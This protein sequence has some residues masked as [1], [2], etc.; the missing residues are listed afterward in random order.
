ML[1][2]CV[3]S[4]DQRTRLTRC[5][6]NH[7]DVVLLEVCPNRS[8]LETSWNR[9][10]ECRSQDSNSGFGWVAMATVSR[11]QGLGRVPSTLSRGS[12][13]FVH[14]HRSPLTDAGRRST[15][16][17]NARAAGSPSSQGPQCFET[18]FILVQQQVL[19]VCVCVCVYFQTESRFRL[20]SVT[21]R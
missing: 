12:V 1:V 21:S 11:S 18:A 19:H 3:C 10:R 6:Y 15:I 20:S 2:A 9:P 13:T 17:D 4:Q 14:G 8:C 5:L 7:V 16:P